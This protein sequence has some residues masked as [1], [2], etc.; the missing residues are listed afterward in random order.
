MLE[1]FHTVRIETNLCACVACV[2]ELKCHCSDALITGVSQ[3]P[4]AASVRVHGQLVIVC[5]LCSV[6]VKK[7]YYSHTSL[8]PAS[9]QTGAQHVIR[10]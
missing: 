6:Q 10:G 2:H 3:Q 9:Q 1:C 8:V 7:T 5:L 4:D